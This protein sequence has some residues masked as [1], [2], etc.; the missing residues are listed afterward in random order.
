MA[1]YIEDQNKI[2]LYL[3]RHFMM[4]ELVISIVLSIIILFIVLPKVLGSTSVDDWVLSIR[5]NLYPVIASISGALLGFVITGVSIILVF[6]DSDKLE[7][8][9]GRKQ[10][11][12]VYKVYFWTIKCLAVTTIISVFGIVI[13][14]YS[15]IWFYLLFI[16][17]VI[18]TFAV[19]NCIWAL[20]KITE[21]VH[22]KEQL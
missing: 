20:E 12:T 8:I 1:K 9:K 2:I 5:I 3:K 4:A 11:P 15:T 22:K 6:S 10:Y 21:I 13:S 17:S 18:S 7:H 19:Y 16:S 14:T